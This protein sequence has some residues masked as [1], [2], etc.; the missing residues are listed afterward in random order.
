MG[1][2]ID[3]GGRGWTRS[4][5]RAFVCWGPYFFSMGTEEQNQSGRIKETS[6]FRLHPL[7]TARPFLSSYVPSP[8]TSTFTTSLCCFPSCTAPG[9]NPRLYWLRNKALMLLKIFGISPSN[10][11]GEKAPPVSLAKVV[12]VLSACRKVILPGWPSRPSVAP[13]WSP[14]FFL[15]RFAVPMM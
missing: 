9:L 3:G 4:D 8:S 11:Y 10:V 13:N 15:N 6:S 14:Y 1:L 12:R 5:R 2:L 7:F